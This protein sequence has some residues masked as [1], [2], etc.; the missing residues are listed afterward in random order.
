MIKAGGSVSGF[1]YYIAEFYGG[2]A[3]NPLVKKGKA[4]GKIVVQSVFGNKARS[5]ILFTEIPLE[6]A[7][8]IVKDIDKVELYEDTPS[9]SG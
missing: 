3:W 4:V 6:K 5:K 1:A 2:D 7:K 9:N 8:R